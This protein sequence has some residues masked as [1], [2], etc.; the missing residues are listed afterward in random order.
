MN[1]SYVQNYQTD[2][3]IIR[4]LIET[5]VEIWK[6]YFLYPECT[7][8][9]PV[10]PDKT[11]FERAEFWIDKQLNRYKENRFGHMALIHKETKD[12]IGQCG[13]LTQ[14]LDGKPVLEIGYHLFPEFW[15]KGYA[16]E[17]AGFFKDLGFKNKYA[18]ELVSIIKVGNVASEKVAVRNG[19]NKIKTTLF[20]DLN[21]NVYSI[22][23]TDWKKN[24]G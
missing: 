24:T 9:L 21:V 18:E 19:M 13:L 23:S 6:R 12:F 17:A 4:P 11:P 5:D 14:E 2:R 15:K 10:Q 16:T 7:R 20:W 22:K 1:N 8:F 3:L